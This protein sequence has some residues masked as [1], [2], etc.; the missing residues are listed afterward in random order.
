MPSILFEPRPQLVDKNGEVIVN[1]YWYFYAAGTST[2]KNTYNDYALTT[3]NPNPIRTADDG[4]PKDNVN[5]FLSGAYKVDARD[6]TNNSITGYP[7]DNV[8][9]AD[10]HDFT[11]LIA[12]VA[13]LNSTITSGIP[14]VTDYA[15]LL[16]NRGK[17][18]LADTLSLD[19]D[20]T[21]LPVATAGNRYRITIK[22]VDN[23]LNKVRILTNLSETI[24]GRSEY[25]LYDY[26]DFIEVLCDGSNW[27]VVA[28]Q[29]R[30]TINLITSTTTISLID[31]WVMYNCDAATAVFDV[32]LPSAVTVG[33]GYE[34]S[35]KKLDST[36]NHITIKPNGTETIDGETSLILVTQYEFYSIKSDGNNWF[37]INETIE[38]GGFRTGDVKPTF[39][40]G[41]EN[42]GWVWMDDG[43]IGSSSSEAS[44]RANNDTKDLFI[45]LWNNV[46]DTWAP[47]ITGRGASAIDDWNADKKLTLPRALGR[48]L[49]AGGNGAGLTP[50][51]I[52]EYLGTE[53]HVLTVAE[54]AAH[55]HIVGAEQI[56]ASG[57]AVDTVDYYPASGNYN[58]SQAGSNAAHNNMQPSSFMY[59]FIK[60]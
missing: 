41:A 16:S 57:S 39:R 11:G 5:I 31:N 38:A 3:P 25:F 60:L 58:T 35:F 52:G 56:G 27:E 20:V 47:V 54:L 51:V 2:P 36:S 49:C 7:V 37:I 45:L 53:T 6:A 19:I 9:S 12:T 4:R 29:I 30:G 34:V 48:A 15:I 1:G 24:D 22:K 13:D 14:I 18:V 33:N 43:T 40:N 10:D 23:S 8:I 42:P 44:T 55:E 46:I 26:N 32:N 17:T 28:S 21:L 59:V 50:R